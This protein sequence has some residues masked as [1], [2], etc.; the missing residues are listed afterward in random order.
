VYWSPT[1]PCICCHPVLMPPMLSMEMKQLGKGVDIRAFLKVHP[2]NEGRAQEWIKDWSQ[3][4]GS[5]D[6]P[7]DFRTASCNAVG[8]NECS[9]YS[10]G[11]EAKETMP[12]DGGG[13]CRL[14]LAVYVKGRTFFSEFLLVSS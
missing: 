14:S 10:S 6:W 3:Y 1:R 8:I 11:Y 4:K 2:Q 9:N 7:R 5:S 12:I 13:Y